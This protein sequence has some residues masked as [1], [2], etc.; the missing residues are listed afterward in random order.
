MLRG[1]SGK[2]G[3]FS[4]LFMTSP[5]RICGGCISIPEKTTGKASP[6]RCKLF[7]KG[8]LGHTW[9][10]VKWITDGSE[11]N[12]SPGSGEQKEGCPS[13]CLMAVSWVQ[14]MHPPPLLLPYT[15]KRFQSLLLLLLLIYYL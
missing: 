12:A 13:G 10:K 14:E 9:C 3:S 11:G 8:Q 1:R 6:G 7:S 5:S 2:E 15:C 4:K